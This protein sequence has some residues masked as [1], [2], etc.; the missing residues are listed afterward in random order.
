MAQKNKFFLIITFPLEFSFSFC[1]FNLAQW[2][3]LLKYSPFT[4]PPQFPL[5]L[6]FSFS[7]CISL[8]SRSFPF[9]AFVF[10]YCE[11]D[12]SHHLFY[13]V[14]LLLFLLLQSLW[15]MFIVNTRNAT[16][17]L[18]RG[19]SEGLKSSLS[20]TD[21]VSWTYDAKGSNCFRT[22]LWFSNSNLWAFWLLG[23]LHW[24]LI[25]V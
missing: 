6:Y 14:S 21:K 3:K 8:H 15:E 19:R 16:V 2:K 4:R 25:Y 5:A 13:F 23:L 7:F 20:D 1:S 24:G 17:C 12:K 10:I 22:A 11:S 18:S 9:S